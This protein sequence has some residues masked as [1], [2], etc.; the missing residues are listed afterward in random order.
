MSYDLLIVGS[1]PGGYVAAIRAAQ[2]GFKVGLI[3]QYPVPGGTCLNVGCI[4]SKALLESSGAY[5]SAAKAGSMGVLVEGLQADWP[6]MVARKDQVVAQNHKGLAYLFKKNQIDWIQGKAK[7]LGPGQ[8]EVSGQGILAAKHLLLATGS[9]P[10]SLPFAPPDGQNILTSTEALSLAELPKSLLVIG[11]GVIGLELG[12]VFHRLGTEVTVIE[13][14]DGLLPEMDRE[15][16]KEL[17][18]CLKKQKLGFKL[19][20]R[21]EALKLQAGG[22]VAQGQDPKGNPFE[23]SAEKALVAVGRKPYTSG[24]GLEEAGVLLDQRGFIQVDPQFQTNLPGVYAFG[25][26]IGGAMLAH[27]ASEEGVWL[28]EQLANQTPHR[29]TIPA[30]VYSHPEVAAVG[31]SE[32]QL[33]AQGIAYSV[34]K[35][36]FRALGRA[37]AAGAADGF[38]KLLTDEASGKLLGIHLIGERVTDLIATAALALD[39]GLKAEELGRLCYAHPSF[40]EAL[41]EAALDAWNHQSIHQ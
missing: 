12:Q 28:V 9:K 7:L 18:R 4:P 33:K 19:G 8:L 22:V 37:M 30:V 11:G 14:T 34:G 1:G 17:L 36:N 3:E 31:L 10:A 39:Q 29:S 27:K 6:A 20:H 13:L 40:S 5:E 2:L 38:A 24:L 26:V 21:L 23:L 25:D 41:K 32:E 16:G 15:L 35:F